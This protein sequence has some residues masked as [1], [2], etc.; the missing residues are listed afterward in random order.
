MFKVDRLYAETNEGQILLEDISL[1]LKV[2]EILGLT[3]QSGS[4]KSTLIKSLIGVHDNNVKT[5]GRL[6]LDGC[7]LMALSQKE[8][9]LLCGTTIG[10][11]PQNPMT[12]F[13]SRKTIGHQMIETFRYKLKLSKKEALSYSRTCLESVNLNDVERIINCV[14][15]ELSGGMLQ[16][17]AIALTTGLKPTYILADEPTSALDRENK[18]LVLELLRKQQL[19]SG[20]LLITHDVESLKKLTKRVMV[21]SKG[22]VI[23][24][25]V[26]KALLNEPKAPW[27]KT[28]VQAYEKH[29]S[30][31]KEA[32]QWQK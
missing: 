11:I 21:L 19:K 2:G 24:E 17:V 27:S 29:S 12:A 5:T 25:Q 15:S 6:T 30:Y 3:G 32:F 7:Q 1:T 16:R 9:R 18:G 13:D 22:R 8:R 28:F 23:E 20:I 31:K 14:P 26:T 4:G 10:F